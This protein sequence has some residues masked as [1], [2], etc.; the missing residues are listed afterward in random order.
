MNTNNEIEKS[1]KKG[2]L[3][4][5]R[6]ILYVASL[7][8][9]GP[10]IFFFSFLFSYL[11]TRD[12]GSGVIWLILL[13]LLS[14]Y[15]WA[16]FYMARRGFGFGR[17]KTNQSR[18]YDLGKI[19]HNE[20]SQDKR[21]AITFA[22][23]WI[24]A[25][26]LFVFPWIA[27][28]IGWL[29]SLFGWKTNEGGTQTWFLLILI[30]VTMLAVFSY[31][32]RRALFVKRLNRTVLW[33]RR[34][35]QDGIFPFDL[36]LDDVCRGVALPI[37]VA[38]TTVPKSAITSQLSP[39]F[40]LGF[41]LIGF[42]FMGGF[43]AMAFF[44]LKQIVWVSIPLALTGGILMFLSMRLGGRKDLR[45]GTSKPV[46][47]KLLNSLDQQLPIPSTL[48][49]MRLSDENWQNWVGA[50][51]D[52]AD[53]VIMDVTYL[54]DNLGWELNACRE[55]LEPTSLILA[56]SRN[57]QSDEDPWTPLI[58]ELER[59]LGADFL[60][61][62]QKFTYNRPHKV[63]RFISLY[64]GLRTQFAWFLRRKYEKELL[65]SI[66]AAFEKRDMTRK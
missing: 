52:R 34:F 21:K 45:S 33:L 16:F 49:V 28:I 19:R 35:H 64:P 3:T 29:I 38:D 65:S 12:Q 18:R 24:F 48:T 53:A 13:L 22:F 59:F 37:T 27:G 30:M 1:D 47:D 5:K 46:I 55:R 17:N 57:R 63:Y 42:A 56:C 15:T 43:G 50:F 7:I 4:G 25:G 62:C 23:L 20:R 2:C 36:V 51:I 44:Q 54:N 39:V 66:S 32:V 41:L 14:L 60:A 6:L 61:G 11:I 40:S 9:A 58:P 26:A 31:V 10:F 8:I